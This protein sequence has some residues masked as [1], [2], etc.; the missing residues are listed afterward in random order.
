[1]KVVLLC[2][3]ALVAIAGWLKPN[4]TPQWLNISVIVATL[5]A[6]AIEIRLDLRDDKE[7]E[8]LRQQVAEMHASETARAKFE[9]MV[10]GTLLEQDKQIID[11]SV[12]SGLFPLE[13]KIRNFGNTS[14]HDVQAFLWVPEEIEVQSLGN[15]WFFNGT[16]KKPSDGV[17]EIAGV[18]EY[19]FIAPAA[20]NAQ[21]WMITRPGQLNLGYQSQI[22]PMRL[23]LYAGGGVFQEW[24]FAI[25]PKI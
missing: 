5:I 6:L 3:T 22:V 19:A 9:L 4:Q 7:K 12:Q 15:K 1:M 14:G 2:I 16:P 8:A 10:N 13:L 20:I 11:M 17:Q 23:K 21:N 18:K 25:R 24:K